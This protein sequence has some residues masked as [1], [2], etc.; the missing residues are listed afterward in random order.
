[1][2]GDDAGK[3]R[4]RSG[5][6][7]HAYVGPNGSGKTLA[8]VHDTMFDLDAGRPVLSTVPLCDWR[9]VCASCGAVPCDPTCPKP[10]RPAHPLWVPFTSFEQLL[11][12]RGGVVLMDEVQ[13]VASAREHNGLPYQVAN[14][15]RKLRHADALLR[16]TAPDWMAPDA[17]IRRITKAVTLC[18]GS[19]PR[20]HFD[21]CSDCG[22]VHRRPVA[23]GCQSRSLTRLW[24]DNRLMRWRTFDAQRFE[25][26]SVNRAESNQKAHKLKPMA[27]QVY[28]RPRGSAQRAYDS[29]GE[30]IALGAAD[31]AGVCI[32]CGGTRTRRKCSCA[33]HTGS[34]PVTLR[35]FT[36]QG[37]LEGPEREGDGAQA[38]S[39]TRRPSRTSTG[40]AKRIRAAA[41]PG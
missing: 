5:A 40:P 15:L 17:V 33:D 12:F 21:A 16:W 1:M 30:V 4:Q 38:P 28:W 6:A 34:A 10:D 35:D 9:V 3:A 19:I 24:S 32:V 14:G 18:D 36:A 7:I 20:P 27:R 2:W 22:F 8:A 41:R 11:G 39:P 13:G 25:E 29:Y 23:G 31:M 26:F 37:G